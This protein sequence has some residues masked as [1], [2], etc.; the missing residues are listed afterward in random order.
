MI[1]LVII[2]DEILS[3]QI[4]EKNL[5][6]MLRN[7]AISGYVVSEARIIGDDLNLISETVKELS[8]KYEFVISSGGV[9]PTH[10]DI[11]LEAIS[12]AFNVP[13]QLNEMLDKLLKKYF[14]KKINPDI[15][16][17]AKLPVGSEVIMKEESEW[18]IVKMKN[19]FILPGVPQIFQKKFDHVLQ[20]LPQ[21]EK[22]FYSAVYS[23]VDESEFV[24]LLRNLQGKFNSV[25]VGSY[26]VI[27]EVDYKTQVTIKSKDKVQLSNCYEE[28]KLFLISKSWLY[29]SVEPSFYNPSIK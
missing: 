29:K 16:R 14:Q 25:I 13:L 28:I 8:E 12:K 27:D 9:G 3:S 18:P 1:G 11:T 4:Q 7:L 21:V 23:I 19:I 26:P 15:L 22:Y 2:G 20:L 5:K 24:E 17:M 10:D 6:Y